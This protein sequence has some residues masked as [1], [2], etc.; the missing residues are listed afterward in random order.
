MV[1][2]LLRL[3]RSLRSRANSCRLSRRLLWAGTAR[4]WNAVFR[5]DVMVFILMS[6]AVSVVL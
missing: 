6:R 1:R 4:S 5:V 2:P 3:I